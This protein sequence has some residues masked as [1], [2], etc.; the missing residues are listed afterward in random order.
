MLIFNRIKLLKKMKN[1]NKMMKKLITFYYNLS[2]NKMNKK[3]NQPLL[4]KNQ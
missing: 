4:L 2:Q 1:Q 3:V